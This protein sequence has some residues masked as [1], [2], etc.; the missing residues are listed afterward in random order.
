M[1]PTGVGGPA[2]VRLGLGRGPLGVG[3]PRSLWVGWVVRVWVG[4]C[5]IGLDLGCV[6]VLGLGLGLGLGLIFDVRWTPLGFVIDAR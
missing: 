2:G 3:R 1:G 4:C 5:W 6:W